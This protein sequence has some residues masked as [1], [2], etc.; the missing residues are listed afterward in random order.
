MF[1]S[2]VTTVDCIK[3]LREPC[4]AFDTFLTYNL[5]FEKLLKVKK[6]FTY[7]RNTLCLSFKNRTISSNKQNVKK[8]YSRGRI[9]IV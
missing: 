1:Y 4:I 5:L 7:F 6:R 2:S 3:N 9:E 8:L